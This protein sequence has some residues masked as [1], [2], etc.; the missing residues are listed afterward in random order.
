MLFDAPPADLDMPYEPPAPPEEDDQGGA[1]RSPSLFCVDKHASLQEEMV[2][3]SARRKSGP[4]EEMV[5]TS[6]GGDAS[7]GP[8]ANA[9]RKS[10]A[11]RAPKVIV[12]DPLDR[13][14]AYPEGDRVF[15]NFGG[16][17]PSGITSCRRGARASSSGRSSSPPAS[18]RR[19][20][21][22]RRA[23]TRSGPWEHLSKP[24]LAE[25]HR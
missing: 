11:Q 5:S 21:G 20:R 2:S 1:Q 3:T 13:F 22:P 25:E 10:G 14:L 23:R 16:G 6:V 4:Q 8:P 12:E 15:Q 17:P 18:R 9:R 24:V 19:C 7:W